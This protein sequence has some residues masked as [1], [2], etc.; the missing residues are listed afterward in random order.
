[1]PKTEA[2]QHKEQWTRFEHPVAF[3][4]GTA[5]C[6]VGV[7]LHLPMYYIAR[8]MGYRMA[9]M[10][11]DGA[12]I[13]GMALIIAG[14]AAALYGLLPSGAGRIQQNATQIRVR[15]LDDAPIR[16]QHIAMLII[17]SIAIV[18]DVMKPAAL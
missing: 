13:V 11:P 16:P 8:S 5:A 10:R 1:M 9:G 4:L 17:V 14:L 3:W 18:I 6:V 2:R 7:A 15:S 12:M